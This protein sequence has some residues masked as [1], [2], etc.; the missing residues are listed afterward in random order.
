MSVKGLRLEN[1]LK[2]TSDCSQIC[3]LEFFW[4]IHWKEERLEGGNQLGDKCNSLGGERQGDE[5]H[6]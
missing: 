1:S 6:L 2:G 4:R 3:I 5:R